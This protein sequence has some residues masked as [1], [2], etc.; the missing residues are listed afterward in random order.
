MMWV[1]E[2]KTSAIRGS[3][4]TLTCFVEAHPDALTYWE[5]NKK[6][7]IYDSYI[8]TGALSKL[9][10]FQMVQSGQYVSQSKKRGSP[11]Y[12]IEMTL[13]L[14]HLQSDDDFGVYKCIA[15]NP[16]GQTDG[17]ITLT[18]IDVVNNSTNT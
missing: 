11:A 13:N 9:P 10:S 17:K 2:Q 4:V 8:G 1:P 18:G 5:H 3:S 14:R 15:K 16:R 12:K 6:A 7:I